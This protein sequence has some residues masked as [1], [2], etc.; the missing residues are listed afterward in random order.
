MTI[1]LF[2]PL[3]H[4]QAIEN[5]TRVL[6]SSWTG[7]GPETELFE[8]EFASYIGAKYAV[9]LNSATE[10][11]RI[12][13][14]IACMLD[15]VKPGSFVAT[16]PNT[17]VST[18]HVLLQNQL[19]PIFVDI[20]LNTGSIKI[21]N[22]IEAIDKYKC[23][24]IMLVHYAGLPADMDKWDKLS[25]ES[26]IP[27]I[28]DLAHACGAKYKGLKLG[29]WGKYNCFSFHSVKNLSIGDGGMITTDD[30]KVMEIARKLR[31]LGIDKSTN[32]RSKTLYSWEYDVDMLGYKSHMD[33][34]MA[35]IGR[36]QLLYLDEDNN[37]RR[38]LVKRYRKNL[39]GLPI[40]LLSDSCDGTESANH[41]FIVRLPD[42]EE[43][44]NMMSVLRANGINYGF[45]YKSN[46]AY[47][48]Y[49][50]CAILNDIPNMR[51]WEETA[52]SLPLH[53]GLSDSDIDSICDV[54]I[55]EIE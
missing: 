17:F 32:D 20:D 54:I 6:R 43:K 38:E 37:K 2:R 51:T 3:V 26:G 30:H 55:K 29:S 42:K 19:Q 16:T 40:N 14:I 8:K 25:K 41:L 4:Q 53:L 28:N 22:V 31:W 15:D 18:N 49:G 35:A 34:I 27:I 10:A 36:G 9:A 44:I 1:Q 11:L 52:L 39:Y 24:L 47:R 7:L 33:D 12:S 21:Q 13:V 46:T 45:H 5:V 23:G 50:Q 48:V